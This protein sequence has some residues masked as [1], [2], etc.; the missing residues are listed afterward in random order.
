MKRTAL[1]CSC[2]LSLFCFAADA[3]YAVAKL[4]PALLKNAHAVKRMEEIRFEIRSTKETELHHKYAYTILNE[5]GDHHASFVEWYDKLRRIESIEGT[6]YDAFG[7]VVKKLKP[8]DI[9]DLSAVSNIS[10]MDDNRQKVHNFYHKSYPYTVEYEVKVSY[11]NTFQF[12]GWI[13]QESEHLSVEQSSYT[14]ICPQDY[15]FRYRA[16]NYNGA[17]TETAEKNKKL[18][19]WQVSNLPALKKEPYGPRWQ[20]MITSLRVA[21]GE[22]EL[23]GYKGN[24]SSWQSFGSFLYQLNKERHLLPDEVKA[25]VRALTD[26]VTDNKEKIRLLYEFLQQNTRYISIQL[27]LG[28]WQPFEA[29]FVAKKGYGDCKALSNYMYS[30]LKE[31]GITSKYAVIRAG[32]YEYNMV[33]DFPSN[34][35]NHAVLCVPLGKDTV[36]LECTSQT[37]PAGYMGNFTGNRKALLIDENGG[38]LVSTPRYTAQDNLQL[39][40]I[41]AQVDEHGGLLIESHTNYAA[42]QQDDLHQM[43]HSLNKDKLKEVL[44]RE[45]DFST[46][47]IEAF[48]YKEEKSAYPTIRENLKIYVADYATITGKRLFIAPNLMNRGGVKLTPDPERKYEVC[49]Y[50]EF[51][52]I[53]SVMIELPEGYEIEA[54]PQPLL[55]KTKFGSY[56]S[57]VKLVGNVLHYV[58]VREQYSGR[59]PAKDYAELVKFFDEI[60]K[61]D[62]A[63]VVLVKK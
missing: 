31:A 32:E 44:Q 9:Q 24:M 52:D 53:D 43:I 28:G 21:P 11:N 4:A 13:T 8:K 41:K 18:Y 6:L 12:P 27:G 19:T 2:L 36:W 45:L 58:R 50:S 16:T 25:K 54:L 37:T 46:Y 63:K 61:A 26:G 34:Q 62:R 51:R 30:L 3:P 23:Q 29:S 5:N 55:L 22:F 33:E 20:E 14:L 47:D 49:L 56:S 42:I 7:K 39:R 38:T 15:V 59:Y 17:P 40:T 10:L 35:F 48:D 57:S 60:Y 1:F